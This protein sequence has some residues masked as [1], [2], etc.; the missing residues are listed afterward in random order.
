[1]SIGARLTAMDVGI[2]GAE[3]RTYLKGG[4]QDVAH[5]EYLSPLGSSPWF[6]ALRTWWRASTDGIFEDGR[7]IAEFRTRQKG[8]GLDVGYVPNDYSE[9]RAGYELRGAS[10]SIATG[11]PLLPSG[12]GAF[13]SAYLRW[14]Y[15]GYDRAVIPTR[16]LYARAGARWYSEEP[17]LVRDLTQVETELTAFVPVSEAA[18]VFLRFFGGDTFRGEPLPI[19]QFT[20]GGTMRLTAWNR[21]EYRD[22]RYALVSVGYIR[23]LGGLPPFF[24]DRL[25]AAGFFEAGRLFSD[26]NPD[27]L[28][29]DLALAFGT[30]SPLGAV[31]LG[32]AWGEGAEAK[33][34]F[35]I[36]RLF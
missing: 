2:A 23:D 16:G 5:T 20:L 22:S 34:F 21:Q 12:D 13:H 25:Y 32:G 36:G 31:W 27:S 1:M 6:L 8:A 35:R 24:G 14:V 11:D 33:V 30:R 3:W 17:G 26:L 28:L 18:S 29:Q 10:T 9:L 19:Q 15:D 7:R 4:I